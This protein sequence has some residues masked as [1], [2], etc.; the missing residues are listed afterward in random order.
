MCSKAASNLDA[1]LIA[2][3]SP[4]KCRTAIVRWTNAK[5]SKSWRSLAGERPGYAARQRKTLAWKSEQ[6]RARLAEAITVETLQRVNQRVR[7]KLIAQ[8][9]ERHLGIEPARVLRDAVHRVVRL[10]ADKEKSITQHQERFK[11]SAHSVARKFKVAHAAFLLHQFRP[12]NPEIVREVLQKIVVARPEIVQNAALFVRER[13]HRPFVEH[14]FFIA[15]VHL[16]GAALDQF[17]CL[18]QCHNSA[19]VYLKSMVIRV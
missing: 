19:R 12:Q 8:F 3:S 14:N 10:V 6:Q 17:V 18:F 7:A 9:H 2:P 13:N 4:K 16:L 5:E 11:Q 15:R 1:S